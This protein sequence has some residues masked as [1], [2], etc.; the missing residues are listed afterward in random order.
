M[1]TWIKWVAIPTA[2]LLAVLALAAAFGAWRWK[3]ATSVLIERLE[4]AR[5]PVLPSRASMQRANSGLAP[6]D[7]GKYP[8]P[9]RARPA[10]PSIRHE[11]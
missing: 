11:P 4:A 7:T 10:A 9:S 1:V 3:A 8:T 2:A 6:P 5:R